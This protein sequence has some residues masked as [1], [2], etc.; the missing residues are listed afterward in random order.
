MDRAYRAAAPAMTSPSPDTPA[1]TPRHRLSNRVFLL[2]L[3][4]VTLSGSVIHL[5][6]IAHFSHAYLEHRLLD[7]YIAT[8]ALRAD[9]GYRLDL[10]FERQ[11]LTQARVIGIEL[12]YGATPD[13]LVLGETPPT[14]ATTFDL[15]RQS[16]Y[17]LLWR[18]LRLVIAPRNQVI[19]V[20]GDAPGEPGLLI[21]VYIHE[22]SFYQELLTY[23]LG[24]LG[25]SIA[26]SL[27]TALLVYLSLRWLMVRPIYRMTQHLI[28]F[29]QSPEDV[30][31][32][33]RPSRRKDE[34]GWMEQELA[35][36]QTELRA[37]LSQQSRLAALGRAVSRINHDLKSI[38]STVSIASERLTRT[39]DPV[40]G[41]IAA[42]LMQSVEKAIHLCTQTLDLARGD[43]PLLQRSRF[44]LRELVDDIA[45]ALRLSGSDGI[46]WRN[47]VAETLDLEADR[48]RL[49]RVFLNI[50]RNAVEALA[51]QGTIRITAQSVG[52]CVWIE[53]S[54]T[55]PGIPPA[56]RDTLFQPFASAGRPG[57]TGLGLAT[58]RDLVRA[59]GG[60]LTLVDTGPPGARFRIELPQA[61]ETST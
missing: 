53:I 3:L 56:V 35:R 38:L 19:R 61:D 7:A 1:L 34:I 58:A 47:E 54:D 17:E 39:Q 33:L 51:G 14:P 11:L 6:S 18:Y 8:L 9:T 31:S 60:E 55:G 26:I 41:K 48:D 4:L 21:A 52:G 40:V 45:A 2:V 24:A 44:R 12:P 28:R 22:A 27:I 16:A 43:Q 49:Y 15:R 20:I 25:L 32:V 5:P 46:Q 42:L 36:M 37:A 29:R 13:K 10:P 57:G 59:H 23:S 50:T 30:A